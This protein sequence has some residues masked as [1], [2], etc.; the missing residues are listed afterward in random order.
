M[1]LQS[2]H[3]AARPDSAP[4]PPTFDQTLTDEPA[5]RFE[6]EIAGAVNRERLLALRTLLKQQQGA[7]PVRL[8]VEVPD[9]GRVFIN[10]APSYLV[11]PSPELRSQIAALFR[12][13]RAA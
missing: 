8:L 11:R 13:A 5:D 7:T 3:E 9:V 6:I 12:P 10:I 1:N 4:I 2:E